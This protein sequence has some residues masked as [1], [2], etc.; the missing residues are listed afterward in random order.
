MALAHHRNKTN[1]KY[2]L[3]KKQ[4]ENKAKGDVQPISCQLAKD[5]Y[6][7]NGLLLVGYVTALHHL[8]NKNSSVIRWHECPMDTTSISNHTWRIIPAATKASAP[9]PSD[10]IR[11]DT[12]PTNEA[13]NICLLTALGRPIVIRRLL[14]PLPLGTVAVVSCGQAAVKRSQ[15][16]RFPLFPPHQ[17][18]HPSGPPVAGPVAAFRGRRAVH[19]YL[20]L[21]VHTP[22]QIK[23]LDWFFLTKGR[24]SLFH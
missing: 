9:A 19:P 1:I 11:Y 23:H 22:I 8:G 17:S 21:A 18:R 12:V 14:L 6:V 10:T 2:G 13:Q 15:D 3:V 24:S 7:R 5:I 16:I 20:C 4:F